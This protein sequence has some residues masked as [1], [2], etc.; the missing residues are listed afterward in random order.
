MNIV[1]KM[2]ISKS[3]ETPFFGLK[4]CLAVSMTFLHSDNTIFREKV[5]VSCFLKVCLSNMEIVGHQGF[6]DHRSSINLM[7]V[8]DVNRLIEINYSSLVEIVV[9]VRVQIVQGIG[10]EIGCEI[11][12]SCIVTI[13]CF[14]NENADRVTVDFKIDRVSVTKM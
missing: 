3:F 4:R 8:I 1:K 7:D 6:V 13:N 9:R 5:Y 10:C 11:I 12:R 2:K 14:H